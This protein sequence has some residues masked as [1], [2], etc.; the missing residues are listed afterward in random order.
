[1]AVAGAPTRTLAGASLEQDLH[2]SHERLDKQ[3]TGL[4]HTRIGGQGREGFDGVEA[5]LDGVGVAY[6]VV[7]KESLEG[8]DACFLRLSGGGPAEQEVAEQLGIFFGKPI[9]R[10]RVVLNEMA[11]RSATSPGRGNHLD[12][13]ADAWLIL[14]FMARVI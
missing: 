4:D 14:A 7:T 1:M 5:S 6:V 13:Q 3:D 11:R 10:L 12:M 2:V 9:K 8:C